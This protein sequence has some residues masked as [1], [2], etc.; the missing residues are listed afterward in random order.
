MND[1]LREGAPR[2]ARAS[3]SKVF[4]ELSTSK[5]L[6]HMTAQPGDNPVEAELVCFVE[7]GNKRVDFLGVRGEVRAVDGE[8]S[9]GRRESRPL[10]AVD[11]RM[12]LGKAF[13]Q[14]GGLL[15]KVGVIT[16]L[17]PIKGSFQQALIPDALGAAVAF[18]LVGKHG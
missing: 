12:V 18:N 2:A 14:R 7:S 10:V 13:P 8:K 6:R 15:N 9:I 4:R 3:L 16:G 17:R 5:V 1:A 11:K